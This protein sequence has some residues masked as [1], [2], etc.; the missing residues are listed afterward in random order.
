MS[1][2]IFFALHSLRALGHTPHMCISI[3]RHTAIS[4][5]IFF[6]VHSR[7]LDSCSTALLFGIAAIENSITSTRLGWPCTKLQVPK[8]WATSPTPFRSAEDRVPGCPSTQIPRHLSTQVLKYPSTRLLEGTRA[9]GCSGTRVSEH[10]GA[11]VPNYLVIQMIGHLGS[12]IPGHL[13]DVLRSP[14]R[15]PWTL[16]RTSHPCGQRLLPRVP[17][18]MDSGTRYVPWKCPRLNPRS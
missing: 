4:P 12:Q 17:S 8:A 5:R 7:T 2:P 9:A 10:P 16:P 13:G 3:G 18:K 11:Q 1:P 14:S 15:C 6:A